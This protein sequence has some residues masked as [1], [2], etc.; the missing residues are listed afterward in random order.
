MGLINLFNKA[1]EAA[2]KYQQTVEAVK[3]EANTWKEMDP[4]ML[5][6]I[7]DG[8]IKKAREIYIANTGASE[9]MAKMLVNE[10]KDVVNDQY[11]SILCK[12]AM[13]AICNVWPEGSDK[14]FAIKNIEEGSFAIG[15]VWVDADIDAKYTLHMEFPGFVKS[16]SFLV[17]DGILVLKAKDGTI[18]EI[19]NR[20]FDTINFNPS[21]EEY[22]KY[23]KIYDDLTSAGEFEM[24]DS[25]VVEKVHNGEMSKALLVA[26]GTKSEFSF[27]NDTGGIFWTT[28]K[29]K[30]F[31]IAQ[32]FLDSYF[33]F[34]Y[35]LEEKEGKEPMPWESPFFIKALKDSKG[36][37]GYNID[38]FYEALRKLIGEEK[39]KIKSG[40]KSYYTHFDTNGFQ[41]QD[42]D[43]RE[44][45]TQ[46]WEDCIKAAESLDNTFSSK[47]ENSYFDIRP[48]SVIHTNEFNRL[49]F[50]FEIADDSQDLR[51]SRSLYDAMSGFPW[52]DGKLSS[53][54]CLQKDN[55]NNISISI[56]LPETIKVFQNF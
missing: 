9:S 51:F 2:A 7:I 33:R 53:K 54:I 21:D 12:Q 26:V 48:T 41:K 42:S 16:F 28:L 5:R 43:G 37:F 13:D 34:F 1:K 36:F 18:S 56:L 10:I 30:N 25:D 49:F 44:V 52:D 46:Y 27:T 32:E 11:P 40:E 39:Q 3:E 31:N 55:N 29:T 6:S 15:C 20:K 50:D 24:Y 38:S 17:V 35:Y 19:N 14:I 8:D 22:I 4:D 47:I 45:T 23:K